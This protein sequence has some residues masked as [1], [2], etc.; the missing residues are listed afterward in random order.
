MD[1]QENKRG[2]NGKDTNGEERR[3]D[4]GETRLKRRRIGELARKMAKGGL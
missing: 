3:R 2:E 4:N 1:D